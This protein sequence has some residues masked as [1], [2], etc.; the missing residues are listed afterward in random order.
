VPAWARKN[1]I[2]KYAAY[3]GLILPTTDMK[4]TL[5]K[6]MGVVLAAVMFSSCTTTYDAYGNPR[7]S[8]DPLAAGVAAGV[9]GYAIGKHN[10]DNRRYYYGPRYGPRPHFHRPIHRRGWR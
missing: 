6:S 9:A 5:L 4:T 8:V 7:Q 10:S 3:K 2:C 1:G